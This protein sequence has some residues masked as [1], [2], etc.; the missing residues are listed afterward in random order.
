MKF[1]SVCVVGNFHLAYTCDLFF[2]ENY[3]MEY[4]E[5]L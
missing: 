1:L 4:V 2:K 5:E 3:E